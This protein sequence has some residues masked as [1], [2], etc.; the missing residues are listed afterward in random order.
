MRGNTGL[1]GKQLIAN[2][3]YSRLTD[4]IATRSHARFN[5]VPSPGKSDAV[6][7]VSRS[8]ES[9]SSKSATPIFDVCFQASCP[10]ILVEARRPSKGVCASEA[11]SGQ[12][13]QEA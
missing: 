2:I 11:L 8:A 12:H 6:G 7:R 1:Q 5:L 3:E 4:Q 13:F 9:A 10:S